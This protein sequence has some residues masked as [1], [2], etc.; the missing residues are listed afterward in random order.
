[1]LIEC[2]TPWILEQVSALGGGVQQGLRFYEKQLCADCYRIPKRQFL[3]VLHPL[4][5]S[6]RL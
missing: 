4:K 3:M 5:R 1:M 6:K 2:E